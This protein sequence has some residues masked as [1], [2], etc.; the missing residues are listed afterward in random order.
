MMFINGNTGERTGTIT[1]ERDEE[2][3][4]D[5]ATPLQ[6]AL[7]MARE[8]Y[9]GRNNHLLSAMYAG[10]ITDVEYRIH[11]AQVEAQFKAERSEAWAMYTAARAV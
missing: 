1:N 9:K 2:F 3:V 5:V 8:A 6:H 7:D 4:L 11:T 10:D